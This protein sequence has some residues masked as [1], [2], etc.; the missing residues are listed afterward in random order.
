MWTNGVCTLPDPE[1]KKMLENYEAKVEAIV[2][3]VVGT[4]SVNLTAMQ[5]DNG[6]DLIADSQRKALN[7]DFAFMNPG[8]IRADIDASEITWG[9]L[10]TVQPFN[11]DLVKMTMTGQQIRD[12]L[13]QQ[14]GK[15]TTMLQIS[16]FIHGTLIYQMDIRL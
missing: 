12:L 11:N 16:G 7:T 2:N 15:K 14:W 10:Y 9:D 4:T 1:I 13:N 3:R 5:N 6:G 8:G